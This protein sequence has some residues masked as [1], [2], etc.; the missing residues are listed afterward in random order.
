MKR[1]SKLITVILSRFNI[2]SQLAFE[3]LALR[4]QIIVLK[5]NCQKPQIHKQG[6]LFWI[7]LSRMWGNW[8]ETLL[9]FKPETVVSWHRKG[10]KMFWKHKSRSRSSGRPPISKEIRDLVKK[11]ALANPL[12]GAPRIHGELL[13]PG[14][15]I[16]RQQKN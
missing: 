12:W 8:Q 9:I 14:I 7:L 13:K 11:M 1:L 6:R 3:N 4:Q 16:P 15:E 5:R 2:T 10:F